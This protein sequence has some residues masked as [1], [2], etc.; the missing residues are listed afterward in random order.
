MNPRRSARLAAA[1]A[2]LAIVAAGC[3]GGGGGSSDA[4]AGAAATV[5]PPATGVA[6]TPTDSLFGSPEAVDTADAAE[7]LDGYE[8]F[9]TPRDAF[10]QLVRD[11]SG[12]GAESEPSTGNLP[13]STP[14]P[15]P[16]TTDPLVAVPPGPTTPVTPTTPTTPTTTPTTPGA[17]TTAPPVEGFEADF[18][19]GGEPVVARLGDAVPPETQQFTVKAITAGSVVLELNGG[20]L[21][22][23]SD[24]VTLKEGESITL[25]NQTS[26]KTYRLRLLDIRRL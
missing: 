5:T 13:S 25:V 23:G 18:D 2:A 12:G 10:V 4:D 11:D 16:V 1:L 8:Q 14:A 3:G 22:D 17:P 26:R 7:S 21:P 24:T 9:G 15:T 20:L 19:I 6:A